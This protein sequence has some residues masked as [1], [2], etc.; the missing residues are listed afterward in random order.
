[1]TIPKPKPINIE[2]VGGIFESRGTK[3]MVYRLE[4]IQPGPLFIMIPMLQGDSDLAEKNSHEDVA[5]AYVRLVLEIPA[6]RKYE[7]KAPATP[8]DPAPDGA[9]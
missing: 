2:D 7:R 3:G 6:K 5:N 8:T 9:T 4:S 1:M